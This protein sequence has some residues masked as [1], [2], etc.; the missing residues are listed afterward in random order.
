NAIL[1]FVE[2]LNTDKEMKKIL[3]S[4]ITCNFQL[5]ENEHNLA[6]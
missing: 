1:D 2:K 5:F 4:R 6:A 3:R